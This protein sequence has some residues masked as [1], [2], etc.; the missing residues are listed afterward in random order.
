MNSNSS[1]AMQTQPW[2]F[3]MTDKAPGKAKIRVGSGKEEWLYLTDQAELSKHEIPLGA[4]VKLSLRGDTISTIFEVDEQGNHISPSRF[5]RSHIQEKKSEARK[6]ESGIQETE[7][8]ASNGHLFSCEYIIPHVIEIMWIALER[9]LDNEATMQLWDDVLSM[10]I[11][12]M[13][14]VMNSVEVESW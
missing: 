2:P 4:R 7:A 1:L 11:H 12:G 3:V 6:T 9:G 13:K 8:E 5:T 14:K 10:T